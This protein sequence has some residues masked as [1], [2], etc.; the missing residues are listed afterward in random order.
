VIFFSSQ[1]P[2]ADNANHQPSKSAVIGVLNP[3][4]N[5]E[6]PSAG[7]SLAENGEGCRIE[8]V[9]IDLAFDSVDFSPAA[10][11]ELPA[12]S[13]ELGIDCSTRVGSWRL[14]PDDPKV[15][16]NKIL[17]DARLVK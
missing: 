7:I 13:S 10:L 3:R 5:N 4:A 15:I 2:R 6:I 11:L 12:R 16:L 17:H 9:G 1:V 8:A 14:T